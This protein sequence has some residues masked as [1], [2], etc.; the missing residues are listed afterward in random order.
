MRVEPR[1][2]AF[3][4]VFGQL[5]GVDGVHIVALDELDHTVNESDV[6]R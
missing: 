1:Q 6:G 4:G 5:V 2:H 3:E